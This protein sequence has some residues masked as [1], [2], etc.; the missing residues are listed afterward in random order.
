MQSPL[1]LFQLLPLSVRVVVATA[2]G[3]RAAAEGLRRRQ[4]SILPSI[5]D[6]RRCRGWVLD[7]AEPCQSCG[8]PLWKFEWLAAAE[9]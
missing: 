7:C 4:L 3:D 1:V 5:A 9:D 8:N 2:F 6:C